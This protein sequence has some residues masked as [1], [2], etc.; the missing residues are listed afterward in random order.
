MNIAIVKGNAVH[1][2]L[3]ILP[4]ANVEDR[5]EIADIYLN[6]SFF[7]LSNED[8][9]IIKEK[10]FNI[11]NNP[12]YATFF[13]KNSKSEVDIIGN[14]DGKNTPKRIDRL[15]IKE[16]KIIIIDYKNTMYDY[17]EKTL[18]IEYKQQL[19]GYKT[20][21]EQIYKNKKV[22]CYILLTSFIKLIKVY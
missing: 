14:L 5:N 15:V 13:D 10:V 3:E 6:N 18:P 16:D 22:E 17:D 19:N 2:L 21:I 8:R 9:K 4:S 7:I 20:L 1:K 12:E 11:L